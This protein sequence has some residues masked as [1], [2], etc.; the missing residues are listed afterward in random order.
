MCSDLLSMYAR[1]YMHWKR[2]REKWRERNYVYIEIRFY[3]CYN[4]TDVYVSC[5]INYMNA[6]ISFH[7]FPNLCRVTLSDVTN[8]SQAIRYPQEVFFLSSNIGV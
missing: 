6:D 3:S 2:E 1:V 8:W 7:H 4:E 5:N